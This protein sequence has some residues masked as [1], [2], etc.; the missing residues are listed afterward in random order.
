M[1]ALRVNPFQYSNTPGFIRVVS[2]FPKSKQLNLGLCIGTLRSFEI[3]TN[4]SD[5]SFDGT[6]ALC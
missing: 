3:L 5:A 1:F 4:E 2:F 6:I